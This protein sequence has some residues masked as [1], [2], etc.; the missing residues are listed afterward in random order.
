MLS[1]ADANFDEG[2]RCIVVKQLGRVAQ[3]FSSVSAKA[4]ARFSCP[5]IESAV[6]GR[7]R[8]A[9]APSTPEG[10][11]INEIQ[12]ELPASVAGLVDPQPP[13]VC[14]F[15]HSIDAT[16][17]A[18]CNWRL[19]QSTL[20]S[21]FIKIQ[22]KLLHKYGCPDVPLLCEAGLAGPPGRDH[23][24][25]M[26]SE[27][28]A[29][30]TGPPLTKKQAADAASVIDRLSCSLAVQL[31]EIEEEVAGKLS[32]AGCEGPFSVACPELGPDR[33]RTTY[34][35]GASSC[36][37]GTVGS[38]SPQCAQAISSGGLKDRVVNSVKT[39]LRKAALHGCPTEKAVL[40]IKSPSTGQHGGLVVCSHF[41]P[42]V[43]YTLP[44]EHRIEL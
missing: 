26:Q 39:E 41:A 38:P 9:Q 7:V 27:D 3:L 5:P 32:R 13:L 8:G 19:L 44:I 29:G 2:Q 43:P 24:Q 22:Q 40:C 6:C 10:G 12:D 17:P 18:S 20:D 28:V 36:R 35:S 31:R 21:E 34:A 11:N 25:C 16:V 30:G 14:T 33:G 4:E 1:R 37:F 15:I 42:G 23:W